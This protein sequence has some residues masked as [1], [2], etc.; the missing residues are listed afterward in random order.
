MNSE[1]SRVNPELCRTFQTKPATKTYVNLCESCRWSITLESKP[2]ESRGVAPSAHPLVAGDSAAVPPGPGRRGCGAPCGRS[3][4]SPVPDPPSAG[5]VK[6]PRPDP[7]CR[8]A[9][10]RIWCVAPSG[11][12]PRRAPFA[13]KACA[14]LLT[15]PGHKMCRSSPCAWGRAPP[16]PTIGSWTTSSPSGPYRHRPSTEP[17]PLGLIGPPRAACCSGR[18]AVSPERELQRP[19]PLG[20]DVRRRRG[21]F[22]LVFGHKSVAGEPPSPLASSQ[23]KSGGPL[24]GIAAELPPAVAEGHIARTPILAGSFL[25]SR[26]IFVKTRKDFGTCVQVWSQIVF[27]FTWNLENP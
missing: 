25:W 1:W 17:S 5:V 6:A 10:G 13:T 11:P 26:G 4:A 12:P 20:T 21:H 23:A 16:P 22:P 3:G 8:T 7:P 14:P 9:S 19:P 24:T 2:F 27:G 18:A 15:L